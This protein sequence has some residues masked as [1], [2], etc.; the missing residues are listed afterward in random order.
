MNPTVRILD[1]LPD[2]SPVPPGWTYTEA[3]TEPENSADEPGIT[4]EPDDSNESQTPFAD[5]IELQQA[6]DEVERLAANLGG[7]TY[8]AEDGSGDLEVYLPDPPAE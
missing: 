4:S 5:Q 8:A 3:T 2:G 1:H 7:F 6:R